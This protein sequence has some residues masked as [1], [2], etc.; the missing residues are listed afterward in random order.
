MFFLFISCY[1]VR[2]VSTKGT[3]NPDPLNDE[4][5]DYRNKRVIVLDTTIKVGATTDVIQLKTS[6]IGC[7][8][9]R[10]HSVEYA[11]TFGG[12]LLYLVTFG[13][14]RKVRIKYVCMKLE[15]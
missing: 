10:L 14:K 12:A 2:I 1:S 7:E 8:S 3:P 15:N 6:Q 13:T 5:G 9:G 4:D 11:N